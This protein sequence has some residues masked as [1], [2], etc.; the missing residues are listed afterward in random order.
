[1]TVSHRVRLKLPN[2]A[3]LEAEG[4]AEF[5]RREREEFLIRQTPVCPETGVAGPIREPRVD[6]NAVVEARSGGL[7]LRGKIPGGDKAGKDACLALL[8]ASDKLL[9]Q[10]KPTAAMLAKWLRTSGYPVG[11]M[12]R[13][14]QDAI[15]QGD[16]LSTGSRRSRRYELTASGKIKALILAEGLTAAVLG[17]RP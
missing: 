11:R 14:L 3:E 17:R 9:S 16:L 8:M 6:W 10:P 5:V 7:T 1:M 13:M 4:E 12:D 2:G 15:S